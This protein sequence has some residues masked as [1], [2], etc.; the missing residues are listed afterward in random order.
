MRK[1]NKNSCRN[2]ARNNTQIKDEKMSGAKC[3]KM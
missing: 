3:N 1:N 2:N